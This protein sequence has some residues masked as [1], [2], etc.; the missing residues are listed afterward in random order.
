MEKKL[1]S[2]DFEKMKHNYLFYAFSAV[3]LTILMLFIS[4]GTSPVYPHNFSYDSAFFRFIGKEIL[5]GKVPY[6]DIWD[7]KGPVLYYLQALGA[8]GGT[9][10]KG[11]NILFLMQLISVFVSAYFMFRIYVIFAEGSRSLPKF[12]LFLVCVSAIFSIT[13][14]SG[15]LSEEWCLPLTCG[16][17][18][19]LAEYNVRSRTDPKHPP[20]FAFL[21]GVN[22]ALMV[23]I[24][25]NNAIPVCAGLFAAGIYLIMKRQYK[26]IAVNVLSGLSG[27]LIIILPVFGW[28]YYR[29]ALGEMIYAVFQFNFE[30]TGSRTYITFRGKEFITRYLP[31]AAAITIF[32]LY[33]IRKRAFDLSD[34]ITAA[35]LAGG[36]WMITNNNVYLHY[37]TTF[38]PVLFLV[39]NRCSAR[40]A[41][42]EILILLCCISWFG[43]LNIQRA[44]D[45]LSLHR[46]QQMF[47]AAEKI[48]P[49]ERNSVI[50]VNMPPEIYL[51]YDLEPVSRFCAY[52]HI[53]LNYSPG[54]KAEFLETLRETPP[55]WILAFCS[56]ETNIPEV[57]ELINSRYQYRFDESDICYYHLL[58]MN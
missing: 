24:R 57:Q 13:I 8:L 23:M 15:N 48:P 45:L 36:I 17:F 3:F 4:Q 25:A 11:T 46:Q 52:Q 53:H 34:G 39:L 28:F 56:G 41:K 7:H 14:E 37:F 31:A 58:E 30:Y 1:R 18:F 16:S 6:S 32:L 27:I 12:T 38:L 51:N 19:L 10:N 22:I 54:F 20:L 29:K 5:K 26:N 33:F 42:A 9:T 55:L 21:H 43:W 44:P 35:I 49:E 50:A 2:S 47:K 40:I